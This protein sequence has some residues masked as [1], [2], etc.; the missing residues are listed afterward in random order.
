MKN[1]N[2]PACNVA[3]PPASLALRAG[4]FTTI[5][6]AVACFALSQSAQAIPPT[7]PT[8][9]VNVVNTPDVNVVNTPT[10]QDADNPARHPFVF[11]PDQQSWVGTNSNIQFSFTVPAGKRLVI[12]QIAVRAELA[13]NPSQ[14]LSVSLL[15]FTGDAYPA[16]R[17]FYLF[18]GIDAGT[19]PLPTKER[20][21]AASQM[22]CYA[23]YHG[24]N[25]NVVRNNTSGGATDGAQVS[26]SG[27]LVDLP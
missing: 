10:V 20:F 22:K 23:D 9:N 14:K 24:V 6:L 11:T 5:L 18:T 25:I 7:P 13:P 21:I 1:R 3:A 4:P 19:S 15:I 17:S 8:Q 2:V 16:D 26:V 12:E 27:Y